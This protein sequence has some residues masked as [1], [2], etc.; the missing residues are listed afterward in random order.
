MKLYSLLIYDQT[1]TLSY[2]K[3][4]LLDI[5]FLHRI[6]AKTAIENKALESLQYIKQNNTYIIHENVDAVKIVIYGFCYEN[7]IIVI[8]DPSY[9][10]YLVNTLV[11]N[12]KTVQDQQAIDKLWNQFSDGKNAD[13][14]QQ[15]KTTLDESKVILL[16][17]LDK[18]M[19]RGESLNELMEKSDELK[20]AS[21]SFARKTEEMNRC[22]YIF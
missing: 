2:S 21:V 13:K 10:P 19:D 22:C 6:F 11:E 5:P 12:L 7:H 4:D 9:P 18:L 3:H 16:D 14:L 8:T 20:N 1:K 15:I 17:S